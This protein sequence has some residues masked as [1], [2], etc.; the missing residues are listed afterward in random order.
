M[1]TVILAGLLVRLATLAV[2]LV[3]RLLMVVM[4]VLLFL[5]HW[6]LGS[7]GCF[8]V[9]FVVVCVAELFERISRRGGNVVILE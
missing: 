8:L 5:W 6:L 2:N 7:S 4:N 9:A 1:T 3:V